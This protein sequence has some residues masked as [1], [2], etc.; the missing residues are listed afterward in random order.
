MQTEIEAKFLNT[1]HDAIREKLRELGA[2][3]E[4]PMRTMRRK[5]FDYPDG[6]LQQ[7]VSGWI[8]V[9]D[10]GDKVTLAYKQLDSRDLDGTK[11]VSV[12]VDSFDETCLLLTSIGLEEKSYQETQRESWSLDMVQIE[13]DI[14]PWIRPYIEIEAPTEALLHSAITRL[15]LDPAH[16]VHGS[17]EIAYAAEY[18]VTDAEVDSWKSILFSEVPDQLAAKRKQES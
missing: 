7:K 16:M 11:E 5:N 8:R 3:L 2:V 14:W 18:D 12:T 4:Q 6:R 9:R 17:V 13:L 1:D 15:E 10:E